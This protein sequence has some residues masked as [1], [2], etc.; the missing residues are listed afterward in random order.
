MEEYYTKNHDLGC[1]ARTDRLHGTETP[2]SA[3]TMRWLIQTGYIE[4]TTILECIVSAVAKSHGPE[5]HWATISSSSSREEIVSALYS[6][7]SRVVP[8]DFLYDCL[9]GVLTSFQKNDAENMFLIDL[10]CKTPHSFELYDETVIV[11]DIADL[12]VFLATFVL[13]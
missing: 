9:N 12:T 4:S 5:G 6:A 8:E 11:L 10:L 2:T 7:S 3:D 1:A 13:D